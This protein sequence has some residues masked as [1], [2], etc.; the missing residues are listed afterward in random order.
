MELLFLARGEGFGK[1]ER[2]PEDR[3]S[4]LGNSGGLGHALINKYALKRNKK[5]EFL[6]F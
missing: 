1:K 6:N 3:P 2:L 5:K 4:S